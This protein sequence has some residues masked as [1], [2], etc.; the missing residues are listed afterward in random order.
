MEKRKSDILDSLFS[1]TLQSQLAEN[2][3]LKEGSLKECRD[4]NDDNK[5]VHHDRPEIT[6]AA[7]VDEKQYKVTEVVEV[8]EKQHKA[9]TKKKSFWKNLRLN[10][11]I[12]GYYQSIKKSKNESAE[13]SSGD[14][15]S[16]VTLNTIEEDSENDE[17]GHKDSLLEEFKGV[18][19]ELI[20]EHADNKISIEEQRRRGRASGPVDTDTVDLHYW[21]DDSTMHVERGTDEESTERAER[22]EVGEIQHMA[23]MEEFGI[24]NTEEP[25]KKKKFWKMFRLKSLNKQSVGDDNGGTLSAKEEDSENDEQEDWFLEL[26]E[27]MKKEIISLVQEEQ[28]ADEERLS[29]MKNEPD[30]SEDKEVEDL[31]ENHSENVGLPKTKTITFGMNDIVHNIETESCVPTTDDDTLGYAYARSGM[32]SILVFGLNRLFNDN[33]NESIV[34]LDTVPSFDETMPSGDDTVP[35]FDETVSSGDVVVSAGNEN[36]NIHD[37]VTETNALMDNVFSEDDTVSSCNQ[38]ENTTDLESESDAT[39]DDGQME[40]YFGI[41]SFYSPSAD[42]SARKVYDNMMKADAKLAGLCFQSD[43]LCF[44]Q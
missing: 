21:T 44:A 18:K 17:S 27:G 38:N 30:N 1:W 40:A 43:S 8:D 11:V 9:Y 14:D 26:P 29:A 4:D 35:S 36:E 12:K 23:L 37:T 7:E 31:E 19:L 28:A 13:Q 2:E 24:E 15:N 22:F 42:K 6:E 16:D 5:E 10:A 33:E 39:T 3:S 34:T 41:D 32:D 25:K 20:E